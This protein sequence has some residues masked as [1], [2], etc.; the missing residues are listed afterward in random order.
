MSVLTAKANL[1]LPSLCDSSARTDG[2]LQRCDGRSDNVSGQVQSESVS[3]HRYG[4]HPCGSS[5]SEQKNETQSSKD[6]CEWE[7]T[8]RAHLL[9][10][11]L[12]HS[13]ESIDCGYEIL[14]YEGIFFYRV[15]FI[16]TQS[17]LCEVK[18]D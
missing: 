3:S 2:V 15:I 13:R 10:I 9:S 12:N 14:S 1:A 16:K 18:I 11:E 7:K 5:N 17:C 4:L 8:L 6:V